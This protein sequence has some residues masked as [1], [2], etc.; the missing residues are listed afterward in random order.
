M[1]ATGRRKV[2]VVNNDSFMRMGC[3]QILVENGFDV[4]KAGNGVEAVSVYSDFQP[5]RVFMDMSMPDMD[6]LIAL[7]E[8]IVMDPNAKV[9]MAVVTAR[10]DWSMP[11]RFVNPT[12][13]KARVVVSTVTEITLARSDRSH[14]GNRNFR[15]PSPKARVEAPDT[16]KNV[17]QAVRSLAGECNIT[18][19]KRS[20]DPMTAETTARPIAVQIPEPDTLFAFIPKSSF[21]TKPP[22]I[23]KP[24][25]ELVSLAL[26]FV[27]DSPDCL[28][29]PR[30][31]R[32]GFEFLS[33]SA[34][35]DG[36]GADVSGI[37]EI[38]HP[39]HEL[40]PGEHPPGIG[41][42]EEQQVEFL[43]GKLHWAIGRDHRSAFR[44]D[45]AA[46]ESQN[47]SHSRGQTRLG[48]PEHRCYPG[49][50]FSGAN[51]FTT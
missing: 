25:G 31:N 24:S 15:N 39:V 2:M 49:Y 19:V 33:Q 23:P 45:G 16:A 21:I 42:Q 51:G 12:F 36:D 32:I 5:D 50:Q 40:I 37:G 4:A 47:T 28:D 10:F 1:I 8:I 3:E 11:A 46:V 14:G 29:I 41:C 44:I 34:G 26:K 17:A 27:P 20:T 48:A 38:P 13:I 30:F 18:S 35:V 43:A 6:C 7:Q 9:A 22:F